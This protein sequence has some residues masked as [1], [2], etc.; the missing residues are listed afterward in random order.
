MA[1]IVVGGAGYIGSRTVAAL[2][3]K[4]CEVVALDILIKDHKKALLGGKFNVGDVRDTEFIDKVFAENDID[5]V[6]ILLPISKLA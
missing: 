6:F 1:V 3:E 4:G 2:L 5:P